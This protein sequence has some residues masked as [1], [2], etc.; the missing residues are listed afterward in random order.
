MSTKKLSGDLENEHVLKAL[1]GATDMVHPSVM[2]TARKRGWVTDLEGVQGG[3]LTR[4]N[5]LQSL[6]EFGAEHPEVLEVMRQ[7]E[8]AKAEAKRQ[9][10]AARTWAKQGRGAV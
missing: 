9:A 2:L 8:R 3:L 10:A 4:A 1:V 7:R 5:Y 6:Q